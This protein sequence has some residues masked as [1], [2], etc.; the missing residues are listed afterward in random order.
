[1]FYLDPG[2]D[3]GDIIDQRAI[4]IEDYRR[5]RDALREGAGRGDPRCCSST[6]P[7]CG[8]GPRP[9]APGRAARHGHA[10]APARGRPHRLDARPRALFDWVR[11]LTHPYPG[12]F[13]VAEGRLDFHPARLTIG[14]GPPDGAPGS[15]RKIQGDRMAIA[16]GDGWLLPEFVQVDG[17]PERGNEALRPF[18]ATRLGVAAS[19]FLV[20]A[21]HPDDE[22]LGLGGSLLRHRAQGDDLLRRSRAVN[23]PP[24]WARRH[25]LLRA[26]RAVADRLGA[27]LTLGEPPDQGLDTVSLVN[28]ISPIERLIQENGPE[29]LYIHHGGDA[30]RDH[31]LLAEAALLRHDRLPHRPSAASWP[32]RRRRRPS[33]TPVSQR[34][35]SQRASWISPRPSTKSWRLS[36]S[37]PARSDRRRTPAHSRRC[38]R[39][40]LLGLRRRIRVRRAV[41]RDQ[42]TEEP[43]GRCAP[44][45]RRLGRAVAGLGVDR[46]VLL[47]SLETAPPFSDRCALDSTKNPSSS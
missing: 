7:G 38:A 42:G 6:C 39:G 47:A 4:P 21:A 34:P 26:A 31:R 36:P 28:I 16:T 43:V 37:M 35:S 40:G 3:T 30:N 15:V 11:A 44:C 33:G 12:A 1:M 24:R 13:T 5:L 22:L 17:E 8:P 41:C 14:E 10:A 25:Q 27:S 9:A 2:V 45:R 46:V 32:S 20:V 19:R 18:V 29:L 23:E